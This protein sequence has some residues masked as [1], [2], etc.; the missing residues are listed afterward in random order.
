MAT[1]NPSRKIEVDSKLTCPDGCGTPYTVFRRQHMQADGTLLPAY[2]SVL[3]PNGSG[4]GPP[5]HPQ[6]ICCP[7]CGSELKRVAP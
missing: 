7:D 4:V 2:Q 5:L 6:F 3:W 1:L